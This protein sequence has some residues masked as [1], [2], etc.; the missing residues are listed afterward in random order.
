MNLIKWDPFRE[1]ED[2]SNRLNRIDES[3]VGKGRV[4]EWHAQRNTG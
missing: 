2:V 4:Q 3:A 1:L